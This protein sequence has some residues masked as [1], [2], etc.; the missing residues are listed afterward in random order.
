MVLLKI[1]KLISDAPEL[2]KI[3]AKKLLKENSIGKITYRKNLLQARTEDGMDYIQKI[4]L[5][6]QEVKTT[7]AAVIVKR[8]YARTFLRC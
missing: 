4:L 2:T 5:E 6:D 8:S 7:A 1:T 3:K